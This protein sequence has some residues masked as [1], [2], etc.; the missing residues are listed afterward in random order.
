M[1]RVL[2]FKA[3]G[4]V[5]CFQTKGDHA[6]KDGA[7]CAPLEPVEDRNGDL[8]WV[9]W[10]LNDFLSDN[11][12]GVDFVDWEGDQTTDDEDVRESQDLPETNQ[13]RILFG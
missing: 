1:F 11:V 12:G 8:E 5:D 7:P 6:D 2:D 3:E 13:C 9:G 10:V 4:W